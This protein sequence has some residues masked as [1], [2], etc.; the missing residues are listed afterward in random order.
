MVA[1]GAS[2]IAF[3]AYTPNGEYSH[4]IVVS[5]TAEQLQLMATK[6]FSSTF[7]EVMCMLAI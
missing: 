7:R 3:A 6:R 4:P 2:E 5:F 1:G